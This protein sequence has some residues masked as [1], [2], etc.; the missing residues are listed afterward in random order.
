MLT[1]HSNAVQRTSDAIQ[2]YATPKEG[3]MAKE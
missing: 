2:A 1:W 3:A